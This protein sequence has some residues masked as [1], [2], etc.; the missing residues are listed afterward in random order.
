MKYSVTPVTKTLVQDEKGN[1][2]AYFYTK[3]PDYEKRAKAYC[4][5]LNSSEGQKANNFDRYYAEEGER[6]WLVIDKEK[7]PRDRAVASFAFDLDKGFELAKE[8][9]QKLNERNK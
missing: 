7:C 6:S 1:H 2:I 9:A 3:I 5:W 4:D 8:F